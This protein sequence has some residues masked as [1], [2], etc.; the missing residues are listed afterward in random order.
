M[1]TK[2]P[3]NKITTT[4]QERTVQAHKK[5][6][7][8]Q[9]KI[10]R[11]ERAEL[12]RGMEQ[13]RDM[14]IVNSNLCRSIGIR[15]KSVCN[16]EQLNLEFWKNNDCERRLGFGYEEAKKYISLSNKMPDK[17]TTLAQCAPYLQMTF[18]AIGLLELPEREEQQNRIQVSFMQKFLGEITIVRKD[19]EKVERQ[20]PIQDWS[21]TMRKSFLSDTQWLADKRAEVEK[22]KA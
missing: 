11:K 16:H 14:T 8:S 2:K 1:K 21:D 9:F 22:S 18:E 3:Q 19:F 17:V 4:Y 15:F 10:I 7:D 13:Q 12:K 5:A 6:L 20:M